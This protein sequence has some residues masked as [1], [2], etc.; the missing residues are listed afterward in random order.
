MK[1]LTPVDRR[2]RRR[3]LLA[4]GAIAVTGLPG[5]GAAQ[6]RRF[7]PRPGEWRTF[8]VTTRVDIK[9]A[10]DAT[11]VWLPIPSIDGPYQKSQDSTWS[12]NPT[13]ARIV[14]DAHYGAK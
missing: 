11:R 2:I 1:R 3:L 10:S 13:T 8:D 7:D 12:G 6:E 5:L 14:S 9:E 4:S